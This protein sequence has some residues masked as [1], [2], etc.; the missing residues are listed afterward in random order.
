MLEKISKICVYLLIFL[1]PVFFLPTTAWPLAWNKYLLL[2][3]LAGLALIFWLIRIIKTGVLKLKWTKLATAVF[4][5]LVTLGLATIFSNARGVS[6]WQIISAGSYLN[7]IFYI[8][9]FFLAGNIFDRD[10]DVAR[11]LVVLLAGVALANLLF[12]AQL[13]FGSFWPWEFA[14]AIGFNLVGSVWA[15]AVLAGGMAVMLVA[16]LG[17]TAIFKNKYYQWL[18]Y[19]ILLSFAV[20]LIIIGFK[21]VWLAMALSMIIIIWQKLKSFAPAKE[22]EPGAVNSGKED[23]GDKGSSIINVEAPAADRATKIDLKAVYLPAIIFV[24]AIILIVIKVPLGERWQLPNLITLNSQSTNSIVADTFRDSFKNMVIGSGPATFE[25]QYLAHKPAGIV[26]G[27]FWQT[28]FVQGKYALATFLA[29]FG[30]LGLVGFL[31]IIIFFLRQGI[32]TVIS[33]KE[34]DERQPVRSAVFAAGFYFLFCWFAYSADFTLLFV[35]FL[36]LG[37][38]L[39]VSRAERKEVV[40]TKSPQLAFLIMLISIV[41][42]PSLVIVLFCSGK[43]Y[44][45]AINYNQAL[46]AATKE[47]MDIDIAI[48][49]LI[50]AV[51]QDGDNDLYLRELSEAYLIKFTQLEAN[52]QL[53]AEQKKQEAQAVV[54]ELESVAQKMLA[55]NPKNSQNWEQVGRIY[56]SFTALDPGAY[57]LS[58]DNYLKAGELDPQNPLL[59]LKIASI[60]FE[61]AKSARS[62]AKQ[63]GIKAEDQ[64]QLQA[65]AEQGLKSALA[66]ADKASALKSN[67]VPAYYF[68]ALVYDFSEQYELALVNYQIVLQVEPTNQEIIDRVKKIREIIEK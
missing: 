29:E 65:V 7:F 54:N 33:S 27:P 14:R 68:R 6:F 56:G 1:V 23:E 66:Y 2:A 38:W 21:P 52:T 4:I 44:V 46:A 17:Q 57:K 5:L 36:I 43:K 20:S 49:L 16:L 61:M 47:D 62:Q 19:L 63:P 25:Y 22:A 18:G 31:L 67:F 51:K 64:K 39:A 26:P 15:L 55:V 8:I 60:N 41:I 42:I 58:I 35:G 53:S 11:A 13:F 59:L 9:I 37:L 40:F 24:L 28:R 30:M 34:K 3:V 10:K 12:L 48:G 45:G 50:K 32:K